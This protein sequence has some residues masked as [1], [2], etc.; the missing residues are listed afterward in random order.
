MGR[1]GKGKGPP[2]PPPFSADSLPKMVHWKDRLRHAQKPESSVSIDVTHL[3]AGP[4]DHPRWETAFAATASL[5]GSDGVVFIATKA[6]GYVIKASAKPAQEVFG[7]EIHRRFRVRVPE[8]RVVCHVD[9]EW[10]DIKK[11]IAACADLLTKRGNPGDAQRLRQR[12]SG[13]L[14]RAQLMVMSLIPNAAQL[15]GNARA[16]HFF[17]PSR[18]DTVEVIAELHMLGRCL[19]ADVFLNN[20][21][22]LMAPC[23]DNEGNGGN[24]LLAATLSCERNP[25][26][27][28]SEHAGDEAGAANGA[29][30]VVAIDNACTCLSKGTE[31]LQRYMGRVRIFLKAI[32]DDTS[33]VGA[34]EPVRTFMQSNCGAI[35]NDASLAEIRKG[36]LQVLAEVAVTEGCPTSDTSSPTDAFHD[37]LDKLRIKV[38][39]QT[40]KVDWGNVWGASAATIDTFFL[41]QMVALFREVAREHNASMP[42]PMSISGD[43]PLPIVRNSTSNLTTQGVP[44]QLMRLLPAEIRNELLCS[45]EEPFKVLVLQ[46]RSQ[47]AQQGARLVAE[48]LEA[49]NKRSGKVAQL[50]VLPENFV[51]EPLRTDIRPLL[52]NENGTAPV[53]VL[54]APGELRAYAEVAKRYSVHIVCGTMHEPLVD[55]PGRYYITS[56]V[57]GPNGQGVGAYRKRRIHNHDKQAKGDRPLIFDVPSLGRVAV[58]ICLDAEERSL[59]D[60]V[61][62]LGARCVV[63]PVHIPASSEARAQWQVALD[64]MAENFNRICNEHG[65]AW[66]RCD[67][68]LPDGMGTSQIIDSEFT[69]RVSSADAEVLPAFILPSRSSSAYIPFLMNVPDNSRGRQRPEQN[70]GARCT[71]STVPLHCEVVG[72]KFHYHIETN[73]TINGTTSTKILATLSDYSIAIIRV[74]P[75][76]CVE[77][78]AGIGTPLH[79]ELDAAEAGTASKS[80]TEP[81]AVCGPPGIHGGWLD[82]SACHFL[83]INATC[84]LELC[85]RGND[86]NFRRPLLVP[87]AENIYLL[88]VD[89]RGGTFATVFSSVTSRCKIAYWSFAHNCLQAPLAAFLHL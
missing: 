26:G 4:L 64:A 54:D 89:R 51:R 59:R 47:A 86:G 20:C 71:I 37:W 30:Q 42:E 1:G 32:C 46:Q 9:A 6:G 65:V 67:L 24:M 41:E 78:V 60:E 35:L 52:S 56:V 73:G 57:I 74:T 40:V 29:L 38:Q 15:Q 11:A 34:L 76:V 33:A 80:I 82:E 10:R 62:R 19:A 75:S 53:G 3:P 58:L 79:A 66:I 69:Q 85:K 16:M 55:D 2:P 39:R 84:Q 14:D 70:C 21:D 48:A 87:T 12:L 81:D 68:P 27:D 18:C 88:A 44:S 83:G 36:I 8:I 50:V 7:T 43:P 17:S 63:N 77:H 49:D 45:Q 31:C 25:D 72:I 23:W 28:D 61:L 13:P 5:E 22:R